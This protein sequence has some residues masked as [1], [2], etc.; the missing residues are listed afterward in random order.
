MHVDPALVAALS[1]DPATATIKSHGGS[2]FASTYKLIGEKKKKKKD[3]PDSGLDLDSNSDAEETTQVQFFVKTGTG[4]DAATMFRGEFTSLN[5][6]AD[7]VANFCPRAHAH[8]AMQDRKDTYFLATDFLELGRDSSSSTSSSCAGTSSGRSLAAKL[9]EL[10]TRDMTAAAP[11]P[12]KPFGFPVTTCCGSTEQDN[13]WKASWAEFYA[14]NRLR[15]ILA[16]CIK[17]NGQDSRLTDA[18]ERTASKVVPRLLGD[19]HLQQSRQRGGG[20]IRPAVIH[21]DL[22][23]GNH[24]RGRI[25]AA[26]TTATG[27]EASS[28]G[29]EAVVYDPSSVYGHSEYEMGIMRMFGG[30]SP[31]FYREYT[32]LV[33]KDE[34]VDE[35]ED[36]VALYELYHHL[37]HFAMFGGGYRSGAMGIMEKLI[38]KYG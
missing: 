5:A 21:G 11:D 38:K 13:S 29:T 20:A 35:W 12:R 19:D 10:H 18:V 7:A 8:G 27:T 33:P 34:P 32:A 37:N 1:L 24:G 23:S 28:N 15:H 9:A 16:A 30:F 14:D 6:I 17:N 25:V 22:W 31:S 26:T 4:A 2:G 3:S 36:R